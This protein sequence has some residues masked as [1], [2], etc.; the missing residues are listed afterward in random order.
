MNAGTTS[1]NANEK[2]ESAWLDLMCRVGVVVCS[3]QCIVSA[4]EKQ[5]NTV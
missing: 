4:I 2:K 3:W 1:R 5:S